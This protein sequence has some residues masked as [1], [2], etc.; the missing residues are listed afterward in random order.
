MDNIIEQLARIDTADHAS[1]RKNVVV[2]GAGMAGL[3]AAYEL[4]RL[5]H[6]ITI[7]EATNRVGGRVWTHRFEEGEGHY[8]ELGAMRIP[9]S[10]DYTRYYIDLVGLKPSL[11]RFVTAHANPNGFYYLRRKI[12]RIKDAPSV[13]LDDYHLSALER[14]VAAEKVAPA[15]LGEHIA[16]TIKSLSEQ[17]KKSLFGDGFLTDAVEELERQSLGEYLE[18]RLGG[19]DAQELIGVTTGIEGW[20]DKA[21]SMFIRDDI[22][23]TGGG[24]EEITGGMDLLPTRLADRVGRGNIR[25]NTEVVSIELQENGVRLWTRATDPK[26][27]DNPPTSDS[28]EPILADYVICTIPF[29][30]LRTM[31]VRGLSA[32]KMRAIR[33]LNYASATKVLL[34]CNQRF[35]EGPGPGGGIVGGASLSDQITR[36]TYYPSDHAP[37]LPIHDRTMKSPE[38]YCGIA[39]AFESNATAMPELYAQPDTSWQEPGVLLGSYCLGRDAQRLGA[40][41]TNERATA[42]INVL[43][44]FHE[45]IEPH[46]IGHQS[47]AWDSY[48][49]SRGAFCFMHPGDLQHYYHAAIRPEGRMHFAGEHCSLDQAWIQGAIMSGLRAVEEIMKS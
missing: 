18:R 14:K 36:S 32:L 2:I 28:V 29:S 49:W 30:V 4:M 41:P 45:E 20:W 16:N 11:R 47:I 24:L 40:L 15:I 10:H 13:L 42:V 46:V 1:P 19:E 43:R 38:G 8:H 9:A 44:R 21:V 12:C 26:S 35:W 31:D 6:T 17:D 48:R 5:G 39:T 33:N 23:E 25:L 3:S 37:P 22:A 27:W 7:I 34:H